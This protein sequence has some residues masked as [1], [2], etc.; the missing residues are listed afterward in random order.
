MVPK[1]SDGRRLWIAS[2]MLAVLYEGAL[3]FGLGRVLVSLLFIMASTKSYIINVIIL[4]EVI[5]GALYFG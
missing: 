5:E 2:V 4:Y 1:I 3:S